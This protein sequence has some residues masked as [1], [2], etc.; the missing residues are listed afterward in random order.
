MTTLNDPKQSID[1]H[2]NKAYQ[3]ALQEAERTSSLYL[4]TLHLE[5]L[6]DESKIT[7]LRNALRTI[8]SEIESFSNPEYI[9]N[10]NNKEWLIKV[11]SNRV[12]FFE[13]DETKQLNEAF[14]YALKS[15]KLLTAYNSIIDK[16][17]PFTFQAFLE[18]DKNLFFYQYNERP[19]QTSF[20]D[21]YKCRNWQ[22][23]ELIKAIE[24]EK[25]FMLSL[26]RKASQGNGQSKKLIS[27]EKK[28]LNELFDNNL[29]LSDNEFVARLRNIYIFNNSSFIIKEPAY[30]KESFFNVCKGIYD[31]SKFTPQYLLDIQK[32]YKTNNSGFPVSD[33]PIIFLSLI[34]YDD[35]IDELSKGNI[36]LDDDLKDN[37][38]GLYVA[39]HNSAIIEAKEKISAFQVR[40]NPDNMEPDEY[41]QILLN[42]FLVL[43]ARLNELDD[44][45][46]F[47][48]LDST[49]DLEPYLLQKC[50]FTGRHEIEIRKLGTAVKLYEEINFFS[51]ELSKLFEKQYF[52][53]SDGQANVLHLEILSLLNSMAVDTVLYKRTYNIIQDFLKDI[54]ANY[55]PFFFI[56]ADVKERLFEL[57]DVTFT[58]LISELDKLPI[59]RKNYYVQE[60]LKEIKVNELAI[61]IHGL[62]LGTLTNHFKELLVVQLEYIREAKNYSFNPIKA[63]FEVNEPVVSSFSFSYKLNSINPLEKI[64]LELNKHVDFLD[65]DRTTKEDFIAVFNADNLAKVNSIIYINCETAQFRYILDKMSP[66]FTDLSLAKI[67]RSKLFY[68]KK[69]T[70]LT[71][72]NL[73]R[74]KIDNPKQ[75]ET[76][77]SIF[78]NAK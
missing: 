33:P 39:S 18:G 19:P 78:S 50:Y 17:Q 68:T 24:A 77:D 7:T 37:C 49:D 2:F 8:Q 16:F 65:C 22:S 42:E 28:S 61:Q 34:K 10:Y 41:K 47:Q 45:T 76:I 70:L 14:S 53:K 43:R 30:W 5:S 29:Q 67:E 40:N 75:Q 32:A 27:N 71:A 56:I 11:Y 64:Y 23:T 51:S 52:N 63:I 38:D 62:K 59:D 1:N 74:S 12:I 4:S 9:Y 69:N 66:W 13:T 3:N 55:K 21:Y 58:K 48:L 35:W 36:T 20:S 60:R 73:S 15:S 44:P 31:Y 54:A 57:L 25:I 26:F 6:D 46:Y 72:N